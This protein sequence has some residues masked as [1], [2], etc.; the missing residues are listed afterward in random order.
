MRRGREE[1][2][3]PHLVVAVHQPEELTHAGV[4]V[5]R[6]DH[7]T[8]GAVVGSH[9]LALSRGLPV[10]HTPPPHHE[11]QAVVS[12][13]GDV[14]EVPGGHEA[15]APVTGHLAGGG[16]GYYTLYTSSYNIMKYIDI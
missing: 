6:R 13:L 10:L 1:T 3:E 8:A 9:D 7:L 4:G 2:G 16:Q 5:V 11:G 14:D 12:L 15:A